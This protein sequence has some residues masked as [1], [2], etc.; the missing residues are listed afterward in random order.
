MESTISEIKEDSVT[1]KRGADMD[2]LHALVQR[3]QT[4]VFDLALGMVW[5]REVADDA[6]P[7]QRFR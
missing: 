3:H 5:Q 7:E 1:D 4:W 2:A 6:P